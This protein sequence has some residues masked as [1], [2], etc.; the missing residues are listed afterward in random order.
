MQTDLT[1][2]QLK[3]NARRFINSQKEQENFYK[4]EATRLTQAAQHSID[5]LQ[6]II[7][8]KNEQLKRKDKIIEDLKRDFI[9]NKEEDC[10]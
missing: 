2:S 9:K 5:T 3:N 1:S 8:D 10:R 4:E 6:R 7:D